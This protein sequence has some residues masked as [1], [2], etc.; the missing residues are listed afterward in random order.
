MICPLRKFLEKEEV[1]QS[2]SY[3]NSKLVWVK[4][5]AQ[6]VSLL[7][8]DSNRIWRVVEM[9]LFLRDFSDQKKLE[10]VSFF[11]NFSVRMNGIW[12]EVSFLSFYLHASEINFR[13]KCQ[14]LGSILFR[15]RLIWLVF[16]LFQWDIW[17]DWKFV[18]MVRQEVLFFVDGTE[19]A[20]ILGYLFCFLEYICV[21]VEIWMIYI[22]FLNLSL[23][24]KCKLLLRLFNANMEGEEF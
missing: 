3:I 19:L 7:P 22:L 11:F 17:T 24:L 20:L 16:R 10:W 15:W 5:G 13:W 21:L 6:D 18:F 2:R 4:E 8:N 14:L 1:K 9:F 12:G 23:F